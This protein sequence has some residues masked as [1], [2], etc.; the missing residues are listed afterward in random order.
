MVLPLRNSVAV[1]LWNVRVCG[2]LG[3]FRFMPSRGAGDSAEFC[4]DWEVGFAQEDLMVKTKPEF[5]TEDHLEY[6]DEL[7]ESGKTNMYGAGIYL[8]KEFGVSGPK[9]HQILSY[10]METFSVRHPR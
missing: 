8:V 2:G 9:S 5:V 3:R 4:M 1:V 6:L 10:W 7:R